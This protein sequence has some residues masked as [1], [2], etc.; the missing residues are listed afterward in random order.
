MELDIFGFQ[1]GKKKPEQ[2]ET[3]YIVSKNIAAPEIFDGTVTVDAGGFFGTAL[4]YAANIRDDSGSIIQYRNMSIFP[5]I[6][7][8]IDE[9]SNAFYNKNLIDDDSCN[10]VKWMK[11]KVL[12]G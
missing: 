11:D 8:A 7:N 2:E 9:I 10:T 1:F 4:D 6:D 5:E 3:K 12:N